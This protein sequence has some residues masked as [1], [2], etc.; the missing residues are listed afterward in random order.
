M[1]GITWARDS[2]GLFDYE[3][4]NLTKKTL[5]VESEIMIQRSVN[6]VNQF[7]YSRSEPFEKQ[8]EACTKQ[9]DDKVLMKL[10]N[11]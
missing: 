6:E 1:K 3:S 8:V 10:V 4:R 7:G 9:A 5:K 11:L 2:H